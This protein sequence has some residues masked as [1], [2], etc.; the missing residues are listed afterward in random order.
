LSLAVVAR[1][2]LLALK[3]AK[4]LLVNLVMLFLPV[5]GARLTGSTEIMKMAATAVPA[6]AVRLR[7]L[8]LG[9]RPF[10]HRHWVRAT[11]VALAQRGMVLAVAVALVALVVRVPPT[12][13][14]LAGLALQH[15]ALGALQRALG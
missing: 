11:T 5:A 3:P 8:A 10:C 7:A 12:W 4:V 13:A 2:A 14:V 1:L 9:E 15:L 6:V